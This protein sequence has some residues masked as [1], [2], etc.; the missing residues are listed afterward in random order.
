MRFD[1]VIAWGTEKMKGTDESPLEP[2]YRYYHGLRVAKLALQL[3]E[4]QQLSVN[5]D[6]L[7]IGGFLHDLGKAGFKGPD[8]GPRGAQIIRQ[9]IP[10]LLTSEELE[11]VTLIVGHHY[12]RPKSKYMRSQQ[13][14]DYPPEVLLVQDA[15][16]LDHY[17]VNS[18]W[19]HF[20]Y[21]AF[22]HHNQH[23]ARDW[24]YGQDAE[25]RKE[26]RTSM[27]YAL[28]VAELDHRT[29]LVNALYAQW[30]VEE[31]GQLTHINDGLS[32]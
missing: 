28:S 4:K 17:G 29:N 26:A 10:H 31:E 5:R 1:E 6:I 14:Q 15:D 27:N 8:H 21:T 18:I 32:R 23:V 11:V 20:H 9:E 19:I 30:E 24:Y 25:W 3:A 7:Y 13:V 2:G 16:T 22:K 12:M